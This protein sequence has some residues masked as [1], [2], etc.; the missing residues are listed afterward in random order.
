MQRKCVFFQEGFGS[1]L[2]VP[3]EQAQIGV[4][5]AE[6]LPEPRAASVLCS[7]TAPSHTENTRLL[8]TQPQ[9]SLLQAIH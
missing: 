7:P 6:Q 8:F 5:A 4:A 2:W 9:I 3:G 1:S